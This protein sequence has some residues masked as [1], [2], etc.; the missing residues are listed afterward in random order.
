MTT[1]TPATAITTTTPRLYVAGPMT[2]YPKFNYPAFN[3]AADRLAA[4]G[5]PVLNPVDA[6]EHNPT[7]GTPQAWEWY[8][9]HALRMVLASDGIATLPRWQESR[10]ARLEVSIARI[11]L[12]PVLSVHEWLDRAERGVA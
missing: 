6:E 3:A 7:P 1:L 11:L 12:M 8:M 5:F 4:A 9:R 10:G 2:G